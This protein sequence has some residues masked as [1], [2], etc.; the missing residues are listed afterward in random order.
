MFHPLTQDR[1]S[2]AVKTQPHTHQHEVL[3]SELIPLFREG[4]KCGPSCRPLAPRAS[5]DPAGPNMG[6]ESSLSVWSGGAPEN[7]L[8]LGGNQE[9]LGRRWGRAEAQQGNQ[10]RSRRVPSNKAA[11]PLFQHATPALETAGGAT[12]PTLRSQ[13]HSGEAPGTGLM[14]QRLV[15]AGGGGQRAVQHCTISGHC[16]YR[17]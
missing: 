5:Q 8:K 15:G 10:G 16:G 2:S 17:P 9:G 7:Q 3:K 1:T 11:A 14:E 13:D 4:F 12:G 6:G